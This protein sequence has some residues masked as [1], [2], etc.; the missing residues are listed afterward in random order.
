[1]KAQLR[2]LIA[3]GIDALR[4]AGTLILNVN[5][6]NA[7]SIAFYERC[8]YAVRESVVVDIGGGFVMDDHVMAKALV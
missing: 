3:Q 4:N 7:P 8:G 2:A 5:K 1:M 6:H